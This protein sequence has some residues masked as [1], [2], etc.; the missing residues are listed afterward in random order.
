MVLLT[1][2]FLL[3]LA[4]SFTILMLGTRATASSKSAQ[5]RL[6]TIRRSIQAK[7]SGTNGVELETAGEDEFYARLGILLERCT[8]TAA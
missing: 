5:V 3:A 6:T 2:I 1:F 7:Q 8:P 4:L